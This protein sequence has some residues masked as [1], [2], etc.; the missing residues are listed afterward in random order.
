MTTVNDITVTPKEARVLMFHHLLLAARL[1]EI[2]CSR[3]EDV[4]PTLD[5]INDKFASEPEAREG[6]RVFIETL[7]KIY[8]EP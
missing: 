1:F 6:A 7:D 3:P 8:G 4:G 5:A 2:V